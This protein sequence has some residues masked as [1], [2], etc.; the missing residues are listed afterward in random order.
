[1]ISYKDFAPFLQEYIF[2]EGWMELR[3]IQLQAAEAIF[4]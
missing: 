3:D 4:N 1:M 2:S